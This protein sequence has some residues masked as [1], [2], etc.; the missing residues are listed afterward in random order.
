MWQDFEITADS[1]PSW[2]WATISSP[3]GLKQA[4]YMIDSWL[5]LAYP[6]DND[7]GRL[8]FIFRTGSTTSCT[9]IEREVLRTL[10]RCSDSWQYTTPEMH[11]SLASELRPIRGKVN[12]LEWLN[13]IVHGADGLSPSRPFG[14]V[15]P[16]ECLTALFSVAPRLRA[17]SSKGVSP[18]THARNW[19]TT[20]PWQQLERIDIIQSKSVWETYNVLKFAES[21]EVIRMDVT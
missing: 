19:R 16:Q 6:P 8:N 13:L 15:S 7:F 18:G 20:L 12:N 5:F 11:L 9:D 3:E 2:T 10:V 1:A 17:F 14:N 4:Q 21:A